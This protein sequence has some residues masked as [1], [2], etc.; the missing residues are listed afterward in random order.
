MKQRKFILLALVTI[1]ALMVLSAC[2]GGISTDVPVDEN[3]ETAVAVEHT[4]DDEHAEVPTEEHDDGDDHDEN[5][6]ADDH[7]DGDE[8]DE[9]APDDHVSGDAHSDIPEEAV[10]VTNPIEDTEESIELGAELYAASCA[11]CHGETGEGDGPGGVALEPKPSN[12][13]DDHVQE[14]T[15]GALF[16]MISHGKPDT[17]MPAWEN[18]LDE[19]QRWHVVNFVLDLDHE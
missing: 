1:F 8:E 13:Y 7:D 4:E 18:V 2:N 5:E 11:V 19:T 10:S 14:L 12:L 15:D 6:A 3:A 17:A 16:Y 9:H